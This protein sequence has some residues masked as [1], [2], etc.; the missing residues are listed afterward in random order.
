MADSKISALTGATTPLAGTEVLAVVQSGT[1]KQVSVTNLTEGR[2]VGAGHVNIGTSTE[3]GLLNV[4]STGADTTIMTLGDF[5]TPANSVGIYGRVTSGNFSIKTA[6]GAIILTDDVNV[7]AN[8]VTISAG[9]IT[10]STA[11]KGINFTANTPAAGMTSQLLNW[12]E[13]GTWTPSVTAGAGSFTTVSATGVY[14]R[15]GRSISAS[16]TVTITDNG[17]AASF[18]IVPLPFTNGSHNHCGSAIE[19]LVTGNLNNVQLLASDSFATMTTYNNAYPG[20]TGYKLT[21]S[22]TYSV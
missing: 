17:T 2:S 1:T 12:Y 9:N 14:T 11:A 7:A 4:S 15:T 21:G 10:P 3:F 13:E 16:F 8:L 19:L 5:A 20:G 18:I 22:I 6:G